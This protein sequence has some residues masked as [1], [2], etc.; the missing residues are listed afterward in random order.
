MEPELVRCAWRLHKAIQQN[1]PYSGKIDDSSRRLVTQITLSY[2]W[3]D[4]SKP[5]PHIS[6]MDVEKDLK[7]LG[8][9]IVAALQMS[10][11]STS[12]SF[13]VTVDSKKE[14]KTGLSTKF[15][16]ARNSSK[17]Q[18][19]SL[20]TS[21]TG[22]KNTRI[23]PQLYTSRPE[24]DARPQAAAQ[25]KIPTRSAVLAR[26]HQV[27]LQIKVI[28]RSHISSSIITPIQL[29]R[30]L[31]ITIMD[32]RMTIFHLRLR[33]VWVDTHPFAL[34]SSALHYVL[35]EME[36]ASCSKKEIEGIM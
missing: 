22:P 27:E 32:K 12:R 4:F 14:L 34:A 25:P 30:V 24:L 18:P 6:N 9:S 1:M 13:T 17:M 29:I 36:S 28:M 5:I 26:A 10:Q 2:D 23:Q 35:I 3:P 33:E 11:T 20:S 21:N 8:D 15:Y 31:P 16:Q 19:S 7:F